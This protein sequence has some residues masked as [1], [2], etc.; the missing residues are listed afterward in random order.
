MREEILGLAVNLAVRKL[1][2]L[3]TLRFLADAD[4]KKAWEFESISAPL[5]FELKLDAL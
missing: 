1:H 5:H 4:V 2:K 3:S